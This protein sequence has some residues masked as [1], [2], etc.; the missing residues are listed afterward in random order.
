MRKFISI[1]LIY[2]TFL[3]FIIS[4]REVSHSDEAGRC[5]DS[6]FYTLLLQEFSKN[7]P[8]N[9]LSIVEKFY[10]YYPALYIVFWPPLNQLITAG[11]Y[12]LFG[13]N[14][15]TSRLS[16]YIFSILSV[17]FFY[18]LISEFYPK[19]LKMIMILILI[20]SPYFLY[21]STTNMLEI[22]I[23]FFTII[24]TYYFFRTFIKKEDHSIK[25]GLL[26]GLGFLIKWNM[27]ILY[28]TF[29]VFLFLKRKNEIFKNRFSKTS[30]IFFII[31]FPFLIIMSFGGGMGNILY[32]TYADI[33]FSIKDFYFYFYSPFEIYFPVFSLF[34]LFGFYY[35]HKRIKKPEYFFI[36]LYFLVFFIIFTF[37]FRTKK[38]RFGTMFYFPFFPILI[39]LTLERIKKRLKKVYMFNLV[40]VLLLLFQTIS[41]LT[42]TIEN[43]KFF[44]LNLGFEKA[45]SVITKKDL[46][47]NSN[48]L[49][50][51][52]SPVMVYYLY[53]Q[54]PPFS[55]H[56]VRLKHC[57]NVSDFRS[58]L[59]K[60]NIQIIMGLSRF[61]RRFSELEFFDKEVVGEVEIYETNLTNFPKKIIC[62]GFCKVDYLFCHY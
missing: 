1:F 46:S 13:I 36:L 48:I 37:F 25:L 58:Y 42:I 61:L 40:I 19:R 18:K 44:N 12:L 22:P 60:N 35:L 2:F 50:L 3:L 34:G 41:I 29:L 59:E 4:Q 7:F 54:L 57:E 8:V 62:N 39:S 56:I 31:S 33:N 53:Q 24:S 30:L 23:V 52:D 16:I 10:S 21:L 14:N 11:F 27:V 6:I 17:I 26:L 28:M 9:L 55:H 47:E 5:M 32:N 45:S 43:T 20:L 49:L 51:D 15:I 38:N